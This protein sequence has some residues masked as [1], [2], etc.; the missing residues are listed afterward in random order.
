MSTTTKAHPQSNAS[1]PPA[2]PPHTHQASLIPHICSHLHIPSRCILK[3][4]KWN[5]GPHWSV[6]S[7]WQTS[8]PHSIDN[9][10][11]SGRRQGI[12]HLQTDP[13]QLS[14]KYT[15]IHCHS[16][17][18]S[19]T[20]IFA[21]LHYLNTTKHNKVRT[22]CIILGMRR[23]SYLFSCRWCKQQGGCQNQVVQIQSVVLRPIIPNPA[24]KQ[25]WLEILYRIIYKWN[26]IK[27]I[28]LKTNE[29]FAFSSAIQLVVPLICKP[30]NAVDLVN[31]HL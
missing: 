21:W 29:I 23:I 19:K 26:H 10:H 25:S 15:F 2:P 14:Y 9:F 30:R 13:T 27:N 12:P 16:N 11:I 8:T 31:E 20:L 7:P 22:M 3:F 1:P 24:T 28:L 5:V 17:T 4:V 18:Y 6:G